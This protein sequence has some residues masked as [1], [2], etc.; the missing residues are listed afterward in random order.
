MNDTKILNLLQKNYDISM[1]SLTFNRKGGCVSYI[2]NC[3]N[4]KYFL[5]KVDNA[6]LIQQCSQLIFSSI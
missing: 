3:S 1:E 4:E 6:F 5:K 2:V